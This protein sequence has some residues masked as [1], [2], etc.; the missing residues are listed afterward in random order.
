MDLELSKIGQTRGFWKDMVEFFNSI[1]SKMDHILHLKYT[2]ELIRFI[3]KEME[4]D[5]D[6]LP[7]NPMDIFRYLNLTPS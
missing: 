2:T 6:G 3:P 7:T 1:R 5:F 4:K